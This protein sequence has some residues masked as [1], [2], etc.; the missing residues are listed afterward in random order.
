[1]RRAQLDEDVLARHHLH[2]GRVGLH[3]VD[4]RPAG[5]RFGDDALHHLFAEGT[6]HLDLDAGLLLER[7]GERPGLGRRQRRIEDDLAVRLRE[8]SACGG[9]KKNAVNEAAQRHEKR[10]QLQ[11]SMV[12]LLRQNRVP[13]TETGPGAPR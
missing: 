12:N 6:P 11:Y 9:E 13:H 1:V 4:C 5:S 7:Q 8:R 3:H 10:G 2:L